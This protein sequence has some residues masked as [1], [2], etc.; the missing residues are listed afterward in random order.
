MLFL[1]TG[2]S[3]SGLVVGELALAWRSVCT[4]SM[5]PHGGYIVTKGSVFAKSS[6]VSRLDVDV[7]RETP[8]SQSSVNPELECL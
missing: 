7:V 6:E 5:D 2:L 4:L 3:A 1:N 8:E